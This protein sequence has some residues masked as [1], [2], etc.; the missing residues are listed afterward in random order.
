M[1]VG[2]VEPN[3]GN[4][5]YTEVSISFYGF[6]PPVVPLA[7][8]DFHLRSLISAPMGGPN[9]FTLA[10]GW[11]GDYD[12]EVSFEINWKTLDG[13]LTE[14]QSAAPNSDGATITL[15]GGFTYELSVVAVNSVGKSA[16]SNTVTIAIPAG[17]PDP[18][19][20]SYAQLSAA[21]ARTPA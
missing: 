2:A 17:P 4:S 11:D 13:L 19:Q 10:V 21:V 5:P 9:Q 15:N 20:V 12:S 7:P 3:P 18:T 8:V 16:P 14:S 6:V 1:A